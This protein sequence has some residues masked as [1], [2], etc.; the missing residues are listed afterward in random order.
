MKIEWD[1]ILIIGFCILIF[2]AMLIV[3][4]VEKAAL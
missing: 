3:A 1:L 2:T 4:N